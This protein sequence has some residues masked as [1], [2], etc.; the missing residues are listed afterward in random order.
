ML[1]ESSCHALSLSAGW[2]SL[3][4]LFRGVLFGV[5]VGLQSLL[6]VLL[7]VRALAKDIDRLDVDV[8]R[9]VHLLAGE[10]SRYR[11]WLCCPRSTEDSRRRLA[12][13]VLTSC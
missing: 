8:V 10:E 7:L 3:P 4:W 1:D 11:F 13:R 2:F 6:L 12:L 9:V 5:I